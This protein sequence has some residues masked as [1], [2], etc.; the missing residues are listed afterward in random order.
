MGK[1][2]G[3]KEITEKILY[4]EGLRG[5][6]MSMVVLN[7][8]AAA[9][10]P[11]LVFGEKALQ[12][13]SFELIIYKTP[14]NIFFSGIFALSVFFLLS[15]YILSFK[16]FKFHKREPIIPSMVRRYIRLAI[17]TLISILIAYVLLS[18]HLFKNLSVSSIT[19]STI[20]FANFWNF[21]ADLYNALIEGIFMTSIF[22]GNSTYN[23]VLWMMAY[24]LAGSFLVYFVLEIF[25]HTKRR[26]IIYLLLLI[27]TFIWKGYLMGFILGI[28]ICNLEY[29]STIN[30]SRYKN[31]FLGVALLLGAVLFGSFPIASTKDTIYEFIQIPMLNGSREI[32]LAQT[33]A[34]CLMFIAIKNLIILKKILELPFFR[35]LGRIS[36]SV[37][38]LHLIIIGSFSSNLFSILIG[39]L[40]YN[41]SVLI[42]F[43]VSFPLIIVI[44][45]YFNKYITTNSLKVAD[46]TKKFINEKTLT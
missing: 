1:N 27:F 31:K 21:K 38:F 37:F 3:K 7:H 13:N 9:F 10:Y 39:Y 16:F 40:N 46:Y 41:Q 15:G 26:V 22:I 14:L 23:P 36:F 33:I 42:T 11:A 25:K 2:Q 12:H 34:A 19:G 18:S 24:E 35:F 5:L 4:I 17:P 30:F 29:S 8:F 32:I 28:L 43:L 45:F 6:A 44:S 20:W